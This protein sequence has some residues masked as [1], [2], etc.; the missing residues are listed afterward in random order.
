MSVTSM[1]TYVGTYSTCTYAHTYI[2]KYIHSYIHTY[3][4]YRYVPVDEGEWS[5]L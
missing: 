4:T 2:R 5:S 1:N 3:S